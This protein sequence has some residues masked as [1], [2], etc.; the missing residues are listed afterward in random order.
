MSVSVRC[1]LSIGDT[2]QARRFAVL[3]LALGVTAAALWSTPA[4][5]VLPSDT[6]SRLAGTGVQAMSGDG[7]PAL[8]AS[9][10]EPRDTA[11]GPDGP[12]TSPTHSTTG[13]DA[14]R[15]HR[16]HHHRHRHGF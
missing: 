4:E 14:R 13:S 12:I 5:A 2:T 7:G 9:L 11:V 6:I 1:F 16:R 8:V 10:N 15:D 3:T